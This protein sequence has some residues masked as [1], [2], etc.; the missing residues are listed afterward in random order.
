MSRKGT[1][2]TTVV[3]A[4][5]LVIVA[6]I[7]A[8]FAYVSMT[9]V[10]PTTIITTTTYATTTTAPVTT[11]TPIRKLRVAS[12][13]STPM[14]EP[15]VGV[16]HHALQKAE[17]DF[18][19]EYK[20]A[21]NTPYSDIPRVMREYAQAGFDLIVVDAFGCE[22]PARD[23]AKDF[24][25]VYFLLGS[26][27]GPVDPNVCVFDD[28]IH[29]PAYICGMIAGMLTDS[30]V[31]GVVGGYSIPEVNRLVNAFKVG[32]KDANPDVKVKITFI[33]S[34]FDPP[35]AKEAAISQM[36]AGADVI[37]A[38]RYDPTSACKDRGIPAFGNLLDQWDLAPDVVITGPLW[39]MTPCITETIQMILQNRWRPVDLAEYTMMSKGGAFL[40][41]WPDWHDWETRL[42][43]EIVSKIKER[44]VLS[45]VQTKMQ[46]IESGRF[47][48]PIDETVPVSD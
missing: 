6:V 38:E 46:E 12:I 13:M 17:R 40:A 14:E 44:G 31:V 5:L 20:W 24:L 7:A 35:K 42:T 23:V 15:W 18:G 1:S 4:V 48:V 43:P 26:G 36:D 29:E 39:N 2:Y 3:L 33:E 9:P 8:Y 19:I 25:D 21:E 11:T 10:T 37:Y 16:V 47:K 34:W 32:A 30:S 41:D 45:A 22:G 27:L 28:W